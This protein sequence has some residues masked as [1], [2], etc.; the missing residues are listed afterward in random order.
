MKCFYKSILI[1]CLLFCNTLL[2]TSLIYAMESKKDSPQKINAAAQ[3]LKDFAQVI[4]KNAQDKG[5]TDDQTKIEAF[6]SD[7]KIEEYRQRNLTWFQCRQKYS[8]SELEK[9]PP[10]PKA[11]ELKIWHEL[12]KLSIPENPLRTYILYG[13]EQSLATL[14]LTNDNAPLLQALIQKLSDKLGIT[15]PQSILYYDGIESYMLDKN[16]MLLG[17]EFFENHADDEIEHALAHEL[18][19]KA[20]NTTLADFDFLLTLITETDYRTSQPWFGFFLR[21]IERLADEGAIKITQN[22]SAFARYWQREK[23]KTDILHQTHPSDLERIAFGLSKNAAVLSGMEGKTPKIDVKNIAIED[24]KDI[25]ENAIIHELKI[26]DPNNLDPDK[27]FIIA[28]SKFAVW[29]LLIGLFGQSPFD[30]AQKFDFSSLIIKLSNTN[31]NSRSFSTHSFVN[32]RGLVLWIIR[33]QAERLR[34]RKEKYSA[35]RKLF[36]YEINDMLTQELDFIRKSYALTKTPDVIDANFRNVFKKPWSEI[37]NTL[38]KNIGMTLIHQPTKYNFWDDI[39][40]EFKELLPFDPTKALS[41]Q[42]H[43]KIE[44]KNALQLLAS[45]HLDIYLIAAFGES[46]FDYDQTFNLTKII[47]HYEDENGD[48][49]ALPLNSEENINRWIAFIVK[50]A[51][52]VYTENPKK[53]SDVLTHSTRFQVFFKESSNKTFNYLQKSLQKSPDEINANMRKVFNKSW[54]EITNAFARDKKNY[55]S[56]FTHEIWEP[57]TPPETIMTKSSSGMTSTI[58]RYA[59]IVGNRPSTPKEFLS[60]LYIEFTSYLRNLAPKAI[61][62]DESTEMLQTALATLKSKLIELQ[63]SLKTLVRRKA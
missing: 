11:S 32:I 26:T 55:N 4:M 8:V 46:P 51:N 44:D 24:L 14:P 10:A 57:I 38:I 1:V 19:H 12:S 36:Q 17:K 27:E 23:E 43:K 21:S 39:N 37:K 47:I 52:D 29:N 28:A 58:T 53:V 20:Q 9:L 18:S 22:P 35:E 54:D 31:N 63:A 33:D 41:H 7:E 15:K 6:F 16:T 3:Q 48:H 45:I 50:Y 59:K 34:I 62:E 40:R 2:Q 56:C 25:F 30:E 49:Q 42:L 61:E 60:A 13:E 5:D